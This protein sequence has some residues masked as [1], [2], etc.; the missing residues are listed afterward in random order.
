MPEKLLSAGPMQDR[1]K[2]LADSTKKNLRGPK[3]PARLIDISSDL[4]AMVSFLDRH[5]A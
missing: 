3:H 1:E 4:G 5:C 2:T